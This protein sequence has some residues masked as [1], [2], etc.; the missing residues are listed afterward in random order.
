[1]HEVSLS[2]SIRDYLTGE[3]IVETTY[4]EFRQALARL[5]VEEKGWPRE[6]LKSKV[7]VCFP[8][9]GPEGVKDYCRKVDLAVWDERGRPLAI[10][11][12]TPGEICSFCRESVAAARL[13][14]GGP[15]P[16][17]VLTD[18]KDA[19][20]LESGKGCELGRGLLAVPSW[21]RLAELAAGVQTSAPE[22]ERLVREQRILYAYS[23]YLAGGCCGSP[24]ASCVPSGS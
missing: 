16:V 13:F 3:N 22:G 14:P 17:V 20:V 19:L 8:V 21:E 18:M 5:L 12:F 6:R 9:A 2:Q 10:V 1:M 11:I 7:G 4:E 23:E 15:A 24:G